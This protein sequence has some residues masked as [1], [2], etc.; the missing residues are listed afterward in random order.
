[1]GGFNYM[2]IIE[3][4]VKVLAVIIT[5]YILPKLK[6]YLSAKLS[7]E[8]QAEL[9]RLIQAFVEAAEQTLKSEDPTGEKRKA[10]VVQQLQSLNYEINAE[11]DALIEAAVYGL[12][13]R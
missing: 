9:D 4:V 10:Y 6:A 7:A 2:T 1:M 3:I 11:V 5:G 12:K 13:E 8:E